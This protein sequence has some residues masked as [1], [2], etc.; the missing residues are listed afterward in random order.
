MKVVQ[1]KKWTGTI[2][3]GKYT[4]DRLAMELVDDGGVIAVCTVNLPDQELLPDEVIIK[5]YSEN[6]GM[7]DALV[8]AGVVTPTGKTVKTGFVT[9]PICKVVT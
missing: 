2:R 3:E 8:E 4:N 9:C 7:L 5:D 1:F 6:E